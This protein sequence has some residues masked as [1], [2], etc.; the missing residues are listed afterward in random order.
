M[1]GGV[2]A[3]G[4]CLRI[5]ERPLYPY[6]G[7]DFS[8]YENAFWCVIVTMTTVGFGDLYP[9]TIPGRF[10]G[11]VACL[12]GVLVVSLMVVALSNLLIMNSG[13]FNSLLILRRLRFK[14]ELR[15]LA[16][17]VLTSAIRY[18]YIVKHFPDNTSK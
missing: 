9:V 4:F 13:E 11:F 8:E 10:V 5:F 16:A 15:S 12:W 14:E 7:M 1:I 17:F 18:R 2:L 6:S 3:F